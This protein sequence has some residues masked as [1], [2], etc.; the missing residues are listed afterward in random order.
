MIITQHWRNSGAQEGQGG[1]RRATKIKMN[2]KWLNFHTYFI[3]NTGSKEK[4]AHS[5]PASVKP[6]HRQVSVKEGYERPQCWIHLTFSDKLPQGNLPAI[7]LLVSRGTQTITTVDKQRACLQEQSIL[8]YPCHWMPAKTTTTDRLM[9]SDEEIVAWG[10][11][12]LKG[13]THNQLK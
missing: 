6:P 9:T 3:L 8:P 12:H 1:R 2:W 4:N 11:T 5:S 7:G 10:L 13:S